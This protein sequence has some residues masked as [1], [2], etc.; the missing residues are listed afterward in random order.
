MGV[1]SKE[2]SPPSQLPRCRGKE[3]IFNTA[4]GI[5]RPSLAVLTLK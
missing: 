5:E 3:S 2:A 1:S 4:R